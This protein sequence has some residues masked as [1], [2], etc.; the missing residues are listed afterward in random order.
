MA[1][2]ASADG[3]MKPVSV[4]AA[5]SHQV[6]S[7]SHVASLLFTKHK[8]RKTNYQVASTSSSQSSK[9]TRPTTTNLTTIMADADTEGSTGGSMWRNVCITSSESDVPRIVIHS[10]SEDEEDGEEGSEKTSCTVKEVLTLLNV[11]PRLPDSVTT[12]D[13]GSDYMSEGGESGQEMSID[14]ATLAP[15]LL[16]AIVKQVRSII[17]TLTRLG[18]YRIHK[19]T[20]S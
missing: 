13:F 14:P 19:I 4:W 8:W 12:T 20:F 7:Q 5:V 11:T 16:A 17:I 1:P 2:I 9:I 3:L 15:Q 10:T 18:N 6:D